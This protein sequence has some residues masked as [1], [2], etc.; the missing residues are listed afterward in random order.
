MA[1]EKRHRREARELEEKKKK[2]SRSSKRREETPEER[3]ERERQAVLKELT[4]M[5]SVNVLAN[6]MKHFSDNKDLLICACK[7]FKCIC[8]S[9]E[10]GRRF[11]GVSGV[12][13]PFFNALKEEEDESPDEDLLQNVLDVLSELVK[14]STVKA[15]LHQLYPAVLLV[16]VLERYSDNLMLTRFMLR[17]M[18]ELSSSSE[19][20][21]DFVENPGLHVVIPLLSKYNSDAYVQY[22]TAKYLF[23]LMPGRDVGKQFVLNKGISTIVT[24]LGTYMRKRKLM[25]V[26]CEVLYSLVIN[27]PEGAHQVA[28]D[29]WR[30]G[31]MRTPPQDWVTYRHRNEVGSYRRTFTLPADWDGRE[32]YVDFDGVSSFFYLWVNGRYVGFSKNSRNTASFDITPY[33]NDGGEN[34]LAV[35]VY[36]NSDGSFLEAQDMF[37]LPGI[38][39]SVSLTSTAKV[40]VRDLRVRPD[41]DASYTDGVLRI[42]A[43]IRTLG[44][45][46]A[47]GST[48]TYSL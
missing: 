29:D 3:M 42:E 43:D 27:Y 4:S 11:A 18:M 38:F 2:K 39:R 36:R 26:F 19:L 47:K 13:T 7:V 5:E 8:E 46:P 9:S 20:R 48:L 22:V 33:L 12:V 1:E 25:K 34:I 30:G 14:A 44:K 32:V 31:V 41:L 6:A 37:R 21:D 23:N 15:V 28:V 17:M 10:E 40:Q 16:S 35:E 24:S 45:K